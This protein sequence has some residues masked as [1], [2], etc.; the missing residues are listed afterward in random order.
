MK[1][2][3]LHQYRFKDNPMEKRFAD[4]WEESNKSGRTLEYLLSI[5]N[6]PNSDITER[7]REVA[8]TVIQ[9]LG[10]PVGMGFLADAMSKTHGSH[11]RWYP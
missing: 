6:R 5:D 9:W 4:T 11:S 1:N 3:G 2:K 10:S 7:D 8:A